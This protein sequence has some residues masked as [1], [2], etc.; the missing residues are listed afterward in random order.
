MR[1]GRRP[2]NIDE[3]MTFPTLRGKTLPKP[4][5]GKKIALDS[6]AGC[7]VFVDQ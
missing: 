6:R 7:V 1:A 2:T 3:L 5:A 4:P